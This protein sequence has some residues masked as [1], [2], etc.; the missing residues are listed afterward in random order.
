MGKQTSYFSRAYAPAWG[1]LAGVVTGIPLALLTDPMV[2]PIL[3]LTG[4]LIGYVLSQQGGR[5]ADDAE[6]RLQKLE[7]LHSQSLITD[8]EYRDKRRE[9]LSK[10]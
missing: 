8:D 9:I 2:I 4:L 6:S 1:I 7:E 10:L 3:S 5:T